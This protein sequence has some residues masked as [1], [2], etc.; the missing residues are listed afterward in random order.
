MNGPA[1]ARRRNFLVVA[2]LLA[3]TCCNL[4]L[5]WRLLPSLRNGYQD[6]TIYYTGAKLFLEGKSADLYDLDRQYQVQIQFAHAP[7]RSGP[8]PY[9]HPPFEALLFVPLAHLNY[10]PA[11]LLWT[12]LNLIML[13]ACAAMLRRF[14]KVRDLPPLVVGLAS[15]A[16]FPV[17]IGLIQGQDTIL[18][19]LIL[20]LGLTCFERGD[21]A[22][23]GAWLGAGLFRP[24]MVLPLVMLLAAKRPRM[25]LGF[26]PVAFALAFVSVAVMGS[27]GPMAYVRFVLWTE[28]SGAGG[29]ASQAV[30]SLRG[31]VYTLLGPYAVGG[32]PG[33]LTLLLSV[34]VFAAAWH[35]IRRGNDSPTY[36]FCLATVVT[37]LFSFHT[38]AHDATMLLPLVLFLLGTWMSAEPRDVGGARFL[39]LFVL[40]L[41]PLYIGLLFQAHSFFWFGF[42]V[43]WL[44]FRLLHM[45]APAAEPA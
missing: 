1:L 45:R 3:M 11:Y 41:T 35:R 22:V 20:V 9:N 19:L 5:A 34:V 6:F 36:S 44:F 17:A 37:M 2:F 15:L 4:A 29:F 24:H 26:V 33:L 16:F 42:I 43:L 25:L 14:S 8:L 32:L 40:F 23:A 27:G 10:W 28:R 12:A 30:P 21:D 38:L 7:I 18:F 39:L 13:A 31:I